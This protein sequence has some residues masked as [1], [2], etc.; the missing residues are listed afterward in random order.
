M[1]SL[2]IASVF[3]TAA[4]PRYVPCFVTGLTLL[5][6]AHAAAAQDGSPRASEPSF[7]GGS[8]PPTDLPSGIGNYCVY[9]NLI[10]SI[11]SPVCVG[12]TSYICA[13]TTNDA[14]FNQRAYWT[15]RPDNQ[16]LV[17]PG[18]E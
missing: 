6:F 9:A 1:R 18:C 2:P 13:P 15:T 17:A 16:K 14:G 12:K 5:L 4:R 10:Y 11:G 3:F 8:V 7:V